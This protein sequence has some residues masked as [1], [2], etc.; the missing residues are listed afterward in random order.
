MGNWEN[1]SVWSP[2]A[3]VPLLPG[4]PPGREFGE[5]RN[6]ALGMLATRCHQEPMRQKYQV[7]GQSPWSPQEC[8]LPQAGSSPWS[9]KV[10]EHTL[11]VLSQ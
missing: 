1:V 3:G 7:S 5:W 10:P 8:P 9:V 2:Q 6:G 4:T 11:A